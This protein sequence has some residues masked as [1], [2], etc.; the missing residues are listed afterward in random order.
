MINIKPQITFV[1]ILIFTLNVQSAIIKGPTIQGVTFNKAII[2][3]ETD[4]SCAGEA[5][6]G[7]TSDL[8]QSAIEPSSKTIHH[9]NLTGLQAGTLYYYQVYCGGS[10]SAQGTFVTARESE[11]SFRFLAYGDTR[12]NPSDHVKVINAMR[13]QTNCDFVLHTADFLNDGNNYAGWQTEF[14]GPAQP[15]LLYTPIFPSHGNHEALS[16]WYYDFF[17]MQTEQGTADWYSQDWGDLHIIG[18]NTD[19]PYTQG[20]A[21]YIWLQ[22]DLANTNKQWKAAVFHKPPYSSGD[23]GGDTTAQQSLVPLFENYKVELIFNGHDHIYERSYKSGVYYIVTGGGGAPLRAVNVTSNPYKQ[24]SI[25]YKLNYCVVDISTYQLTFKAYDT[26]NVQI[27]SFQIVKNTPTPSHTATPTPKICLAGDVNCDNEITPGDALLA[28]N[29]YVETYTPT[30]DE[31]CNVM[32]A[33]DFDSS[34]S[35]TPGDALCI[36]L[37]YIEKPC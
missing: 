27:D 4:S 31:P 18:L 19:K 10:T 22:N 29:I 21:Q 8:G 24:V 6:Y 34:G 33:A 30:G 13:Q 26:N 11:T 16:H 1:A 37:Q 7:L 5:R 23:H 35:V 9:V 32:C 2:M 25:G 28:F 17:K 14:F 15:L 20:S 12:T 3:W 36:F